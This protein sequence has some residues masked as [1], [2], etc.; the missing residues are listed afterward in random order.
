MKTI[1]IDEVMHKRIRQLAVTT[2]KKIYELIKE[3]L[4]YLEEKYHI[5]RNN[6]ISNHE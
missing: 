3:A 1:G 6:E 4:D 5:T 2:D